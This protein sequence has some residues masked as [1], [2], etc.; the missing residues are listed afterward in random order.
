MVVEEETK[1]AEVEALEIVKSQRWRLS[2][3]SNLWMK[4]LLVIVEAAM[5]RS[6]D[7]ERMVEDEEDI[8]DYLGR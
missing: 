3:N 6:L 8:L 1:V 7:V 2:S 5:E 4:N